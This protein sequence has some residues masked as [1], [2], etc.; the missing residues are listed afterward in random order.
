MPS[1]RSRSIEILKS[2][3]HRFFSLIYLSTFLLSLHYAFI[4]YISS[5]FLSSF[6][7]GEILG[8]FYIFGAI[9]NVIIL[10]NTSRIL[11]KFGNWRSATSLL[12]IEALT[13]LV[14]S[15][16]HSA[17]LILL[18]FIIH[19]AVAPFIYFNLDIF[20]ETELKTETHTG[21]V[22]G[23]FLAMGNLAYVI[24]PALAGMVVGTNNFQGAFFV[25]FLIIV[26]LFFILWCRPLRNFRDASYPSVNIRKNI[27]QFYEKRDLRNVFAVNFILQFFYVWMIIYTPIYLYEN[28]GF[29]LDQ[30][31]LYVF[32]DAPAFHNFPDSR[33]IVADTRH[34]EREMII[35]GLVI[36]GAATILLPSVGGTSIVMW[37]ILLFVTRIG[38]SIVEIMSESYFFKHTKGKD[39][40]PIS[41]FRTTSPLSYII[42]P[43]AAIFAFAL[44]DFKDS[45]ILVG[46]VVLFGIYFAG[47]LKDVR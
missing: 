37:T 38:A 13:L 43:I 22:R 7:S 41:I 5:S 29:S 12:F 15:F 8:F 1:Q 45:F 44:A 31:R 24:A 19:I 18:A 30:H 47:K 26:P 39:A 6:V 32:R 46:I 14:I 3:E 17:Y 4:L 34:D 36:M 16:S 40:G 11:R 2:K 10:L 33:R 23:I 21:G 28:L 25:S 27:R 9:L 35:W 42:M 20:I